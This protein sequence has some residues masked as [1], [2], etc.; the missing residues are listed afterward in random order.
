MIYLFIYFLREI[1]S[2][3]RDRFCVMEMGKYLEILDAG[4][5]IVARFHSHCPQTG[6]LYYHPPANSDDHHHHRF[7]SSATCVDNNITR[8]SQNRFGAANMIILQLEMLI[9]FQKLFQS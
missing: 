1:V 9:W 8:K 5:R 6:C 7:H 2:I 3:F 4:M